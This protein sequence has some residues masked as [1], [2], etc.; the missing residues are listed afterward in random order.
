MGVSTG[1][2]SSFSPVSQLAVKRCHAIGTKQSNFVCSR[3]LSKG[4]SELVCSTKSIS[5]HSVCHCHPAAEA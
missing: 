2:A 1:N 5:L 3:T 4:A